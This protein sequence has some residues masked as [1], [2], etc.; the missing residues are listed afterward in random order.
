MDNRGG[1]PPPPPARG[2]AYPGN[3]NSNFSEEG[4]Y[5]KHMVLLRGRPQRTTAQNLEKLTLS[6]VRKMSA[7]AQPLSL[8]ERADTP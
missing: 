6:L 3:K 4:N 1:P 8:L 7:L 2:P 5:S